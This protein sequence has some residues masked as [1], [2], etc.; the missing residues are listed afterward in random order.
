MYSGDGSVLILYA[1]SVVLLLVLAGKEEG[2]KVLLWTALPVVLIVFNPV[3]GLLL[4]RF[5]ILPER[6][7]RLY[8]LLPVG[9]TVAYSFSLLSARFATRYPK[10]PVL[11]APL[12]LCAILLLTGIPVQSEETFQKAENPYKLP[13]EVIGLTDAVNAD[14]ADRKERLTVFPPE[15]CAYPRLYDATLPVLYGRYPQD[16]AGVD[17]FDNLN[18][19]SVNLRRVIETSESA[20]ADYLILNRARDYETAPE[21]VLPAPIATVGDYCLYRLN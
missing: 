1:A 14:C 12:L 21:E 6:L 11:F 16:Y 18:Q 4:E 17:V 8:W 13:A 20:G 7:V 19:A 5:A 15:L 2:T 9:L 3:A 10:A